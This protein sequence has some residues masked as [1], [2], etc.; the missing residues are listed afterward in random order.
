MLQQLQNVLVGTAAEAGA[1]N[2]PHFRLIAK[3]KVINTT[4]SPVE[5]EDRSLELGF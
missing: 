1:L 5:Q 3:L 4:N 2:V